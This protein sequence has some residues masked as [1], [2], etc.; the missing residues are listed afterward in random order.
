MP[1]QYN[2][3][4]I[5]F[6]VLRTNIIYFLTHSSVEAITISSLHFKITLIMII[7]TKLH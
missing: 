3:I 7:D 1:V 5:D 6:L 2:S 4:T